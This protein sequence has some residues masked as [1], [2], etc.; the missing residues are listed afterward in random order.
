MK[1]MVSKSLIAAAVAAASLFGATSAQAAVFNPF[2]VQPTNPA[3]A[4]FVADK[5]TGNYTEIITFNAGGTF[6][7]SL[8]WTAGQFVTGGGNTTIGANKSRLGN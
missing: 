1:A 4:A 7:V 6:D 3:K 8:M 5:I 2:T